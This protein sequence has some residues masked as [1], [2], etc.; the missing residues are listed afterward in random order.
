MKL[1]KNASDEREPVG[2]DI[3]TA[4]IVVYK[5]GC[6]EG[7]IQ[8]ESNAFFTVPSL[9]Q[10]KEFLMDNNVQFFDKNGSLYIFGNS[11]DEIA[12]ILSEQTKHPMESGM[13]N[14][15]EVE[16][17]NVIQAILR[18]LIAP[19]KKENEALWF[20]IPGK[21]IDSDAS[22]I[23]NESIFKTFLTG[24][25]YSPRSVNEA[26]AVVVSEVST[27][28]ATAIGISIG[29]GMCNVCCSYLCIPVV[30]YSIRMGGDSID[31]MVAVSVGDSPAKIKAIKEEELNLSIPPKNSIEHGLHVCYENLFTTLAESLEH[32]LGASDSVPKLREAVPIILSGGTV[33]APGS[34][35]KFASVLRKFKLPF[36]VSDIILAKNPLHATA[37]GAYL[38]AEGKE[39]PM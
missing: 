37:I 24:L 13:L 39:C 36:R 30:T 38:M 3:G 25:G 35:D 10:T 34:R 7:S 32:V 8:M 15:G 20:S 1:Q 17:I 12:G 2:L 19:P 22:V 18:R 9:P 23:F 6:P 29:A 14:L 27:D 4:N 33:L 28:H 11:A 5:N 21:P 16:G 31:K 26:M